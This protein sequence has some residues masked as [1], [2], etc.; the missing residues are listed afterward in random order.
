MAAL[1]RILQIIGWLWVAFGVLGPMFGLPGFPW[2][3]GLIL[4][5][6]SRVVRA[7]ASQME[8]D[9]LGDD[10]PV[11]NVERTP[12]PPKTRA[13][14]APMTARPAPIVV[15]PSRTEIEQK[16]VATMR[17]EIDTTDQDEVDE[18]LAQIHDVGRPKSSAEMIAEARQ[19]WNKRP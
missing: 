17:D 8:R 2:F 4:L 5:L 9:A 7:R 14:P 15:E 6:I 13:N 18:L 1:G 12:D 10:T 16:L 19:R 3:A 11:P